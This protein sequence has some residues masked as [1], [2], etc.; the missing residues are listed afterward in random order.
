[1]HTPAEFA[2]AMDAAAAGDVIILAKGQ[3]TDA[4]LAIK[5]G[6]T[7]VAPLTIR[8][9]VPGETILNGS[10][11]LHLDAP[12]VV[13]DGL[14]FYQGA[15]RKGAVIE[16]NSDHATVRN[17]AVVD[18]NPPSFD[19]KYYWVFFSGNHNTI[20][21]CYFK[22]KNHLEPVIG[23]AIEGATYNRVLG[24]LFINIPYADAN[25]RENIR[26]WGPGKFD[27][28]ADGGAYFTIAGN[29]F[30]HADGEGA[31]IISLKSNHN[32]VINNT[33]IATRGCVN[34]R[35][36]SFNLI[37]GN[38]ILGQGRPG[39]QGLRM[40][41]RNNVVQ[42]NYV[43]G[44][45]YGI[46]VSTGEYVD[47]ALTPQYEPKAK[48]A[49]GQT[50]GKGAMATYAQVRDL[51]LADNVTVGIRG[52][53]LEVGF[54]YQRRWP[55][56][57][58]V[59]LPENCVIRNNRFV[60]PA[61]GVSVIGTTPPDAPPFNE[62]HF[63]PNRYE[64][65]RLLGGTSAFAPAATGCVSEPLPDGWSE[66]AE[67]KKLKPLTPAD[68]GPPWVIALRAAGKFPMEQAAVGERTPAPTEDPK[69]GNAREKRG[70]AKRAN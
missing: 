46:R 30:D 10:S 4:P 41:G 60:R 12:H 40:S 28:G 37:Q 8:A 24:C 48:T 69:A 26:V 44:C 70:K 58:M 67:Q 54:D 14:F 13:V 5:R 43:S 16:F 61:G 22:G 62:F 64:A 25:G 29:L 39:T 33:V 38:L 53:D 47:R 35:Q 68:V 21:R 17:T 57:Q 63:A 32:Q 36:G 2:V 56:E 31:E 20:E 3:W 11:S 42:G 51:T 65:N 19:T 45:D 50:V 55:T 66:A 1:V 23:N 34:I 52:A 59:L 6:G 9:E 18:Y 7:A 49:N 27:A 15:I